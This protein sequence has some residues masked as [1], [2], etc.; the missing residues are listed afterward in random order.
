MFEHSPTTIPIP[1][2]RQ[3]ELKTLRRS[4]LWWFAQLHPSTLKSSRILRLLQLPSKDLR[5]RKARRSVGTYVIPD[6]NTTMHSQ[7]T[8]ISKE[9]SNFTTLGLKLIP[10]TYTQNAMSWLLNLV[11]FTSSCYD[12]QC[13]ISSILSPLYP[14][15]TIL[16]P[17]SCNKSVNNTLFH[18][19]R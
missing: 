16:T 3:L 7:V 12:Q 13:N 5:V 8:L 4:L 2:L 19:W 9:M 10:R 1:W 11:W 18:R 6:L 14:H 17:L 15:S